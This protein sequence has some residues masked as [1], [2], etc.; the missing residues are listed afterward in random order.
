[1]S[2]TGSEIGATRGQLAVSAVPRVEVLA[3][4]IECCSECKCIGVMRAISA[5]ATS[6]WVGLRRCCKLELARVNCGVVK[7]RNLSHLIFCLETAKGF[8]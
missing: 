2:F 4:R 1:M 5:R 7:L 8:S 3:R 6:F